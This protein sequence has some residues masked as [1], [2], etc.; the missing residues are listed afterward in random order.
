M[1]PLI[2]WD[3]LV[4]Q[5]KA[6]E[7]AGMEQLYRI[8]CRGIRFYLHRHIRP[9][10]VDDQVHDT[11]MIVVQAIQ[12]GDLREPERL[13]GFVRTVVHRQ[14]AGYIAKVVNT[15]RDDIEAGVPVVDQAQSPEQ[16]VM[17]NERTALMK[18]A[19]AS[20][21]AKDREILIR[22]YLKEESQEQI[23]GEM[24]LTETQFRLTKSR[25]KA[26]FGVIGRKKLEARET[27]PVVR[28]AA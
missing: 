17:T 22:Y 6:G 20:L 27:C 2:N 11:F 13:M 23:C 7:D 16:R 3:D 12:R 14:V 21:S 15:R 4:A 1:Y 28:Q 26:K 18:T 25:A 5:I 9:E 19:L 8:F 10:E 24:S